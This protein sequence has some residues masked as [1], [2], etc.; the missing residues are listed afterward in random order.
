ME[1]FC[2]NFTNHWGLPQVNGNHPNSFPLTSAAG[3]R[4]AENRTCDEAAKKKK[5]G[6]ELH[7][8]SQCTQTT[9]ITH[10][11]IHIYTYTN[12]IIKVYVYIYIFNIIYNL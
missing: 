5:T 12:M 2:T 3:C 10:T 1:D 7:F 6:H 4:Q 8:M 9:R 11:H